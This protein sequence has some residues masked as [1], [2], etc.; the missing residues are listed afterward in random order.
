MTPSIFAWIASVMYGVEAIAGKLTSRHSI[1]NPWL[2]NFF[3]AFFI[4][5][6]TV[7]VALWQGVS[8]P[9]QW[10]DVILASLFYALASAL[11]V[12]ALYKIDVSIVGS[13]YNFRTVVTVILG[14]LFLGEILSTQQ[15][16]LICVVVIAGIFVS[17]DER[18]SIKSFFTRGI[19]IA[20]LGVLSSALM[21]IFIKG[22]VAE[23]G[24]WNTTLWIEIL[25]QVWLLPTILLFRKDIVSSTL[26][27]YMVTA[28]TAI[29]GV[30]GTLAAVKAYAANVSISST[31]ISL[32]F[33]LIMAFLFSTF[34][35]EL[36]EK[37]TLKVYIIRFIS[38][39]TMI[40]AALNL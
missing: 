15:Y 22:A 13:L 4:L 27:Q 10:L 6:F 18:F 34:A 33:S 36:L 40:V 17:V 25:G 19:G 9:A 23:T 8:M 5:L 7:P 31:I 37:H 26:K 24:Y 14:A 21:A 38:A 28:A 2:F 39:A 20:I 3:W 32:P 35:P 1:Q 29:A 11:Y 30:I 12:L 16:L